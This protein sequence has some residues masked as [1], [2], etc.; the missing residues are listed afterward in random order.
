MIIVKGDYLEKLA[1]VMVNYSAGVKE[2]MKVL[3]I[4]PTCAEQA[5]LEAY[6]EVL[7]AGAHPII[8]P[9]SHHAKEIFFENASDAQL[10]QVDISIDYLYRTVDRALEFIAETNTKAFSRV[11]SSRLAR[12][13]KAYADMIK[14]VS[15]RERRGEYKWVLTAYP[16]DAQAQEASMSL[17]QFEE[18]VYNAC[19]FGEDDP[20]PGMEGH[21]CQTGNDM[22]MAQ[23]KGRDQVCWTGYRHNVFHERKNL[24]QLRRPHQLSRRRGVHMP[25]RGQRPGYDTV[26]LPP[27]L[28]GKRD[29]GR[30]PHVQG[31]RGRLS[32]CRQGPEAP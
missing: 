8:Y 27:H 9:E 19:L 6:K 24:A 30:A 29:R 13:Q 20:H 26:H 12:A 17:L 31:R 25:S 32:V 15:E 14:A 10:D 1:N 22:H 4:G 18:F 5:M 23:Q 28:H 3:I 16:T 11:D 7:K 2:G 21:L